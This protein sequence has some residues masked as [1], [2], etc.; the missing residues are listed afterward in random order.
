M[1]AVEGVV[2]QLRV[3]ARVASFAAYCIG[4]YAQ[5]E[6]ISR[7]RGE[8]N[9]RQL[10]YIRR[11]GRRILDTWGVELIARGP[12]VERGEQVPRKG[13]NGKGRIFVS[14]HRSMLDIAVTI[15]LVEGRHVS[16][17]D[18]SKWPVVGLVARRAGTLF[19]ERDSRSSGAKVVLEMVNQ[20]EKGEGVVMYPEGTTFDGDEVRPFRHGA[21]TAAKRTDA[22]VVP[23]GLAYEGAAASF[24]DESFTEHMMR[25]SRARRTRCAAVV[26]E[27]IASAGLQLEALKNRTHD[28]VQDLVHQARKVLAER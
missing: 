9:E 11:W 28:A 20:V 1:N 12:Y 18:L 5:Y 4:L 2:E 22:E 16:R 13:A 17:A 23:I 21:F 7:V 8:S 27:P 15:D 3:P 10:R 25:V 19:V 24:G 6:T 26:G 14:N